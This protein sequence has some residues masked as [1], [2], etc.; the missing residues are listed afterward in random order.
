MSPKSVLRRLG[1]AAALAFAVGGAAS[2]AD[3]PDGLI[4]DPH[5]GDTLFHFYQDHYFTS[6]TGLMVSQHFNRVS[7]HADEAEVLRGGLLLSYGMHKEAGDIFALL[8]EKGAAPPVRD[9]AWFFLAKIRYQRGFFAEA[10]DALGRIE[11]NLPP[12]LEEERVLLKANVAMAR[13]DYATT[14]TVLNSMADPAKEISKGTTSASLYARYN[15]GVA[16]VRSGNP[17]GGSALLDQLGKAPTPPDATE[18]FRSLRDKA[19]VA[20]GFTALQDNKPEAAGPYLERVRLNGSQSNKALLGFG[21]SY[22][23]LKDHKKAL[24]PWT[25]LS[26]RDTSDSAVL[27]ASIALPYAFGQLGAYGQALERYTAAITVYERENT[28]L[29]ESI[30]AIRA[31]KLI[32][33]LLERNPGEE[34]GW[35]WSIRELPQMPHGGH[36]TQVL[37]QHEFQ[38]AFKNY[39]DLQFLTGNLQQWKDSLVVFGDVLDTRRKAYTER[40]PL[41]L[42]KARDI[43][44]SDMSV[45]GAALATALTEAETQADG[46]AFADPKER[47]LLDRLDGVQANLKA[48]GDTP[49]VNAA[50]ERQRLVAGALTWQLAQSY[51]ARLYEAKRALQTLEA[52]INEAKQREAA[53]VQAQRDEPARF[54]QFALRIAELDKRIQALI[55][56]VATLSKEQQGALQELAVA[57]LTRQKDRLV[58][59]STQARFAVAQLYD[60]ADKA[61]EPQPKPAAP[62]DADNAP[63]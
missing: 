36:L 50:R 48:L 25:E 40:L 43:G 30:A 37:S 29:D 47:E 41:V 55:P 42:A 54:D 8:I 53:L 58:A 2:A 31:G 16:L 3:K 9:R 34:M 10:D 1:A 57:E 18:E 49:D 28:G 6:V 45:R 12:D 14:V 22:A 27:E 56:L 15:L 19:N 52:G 51:T 35:F 46:T 63:K 20:L 13:G 4:K 60:R 39:R 11:K 33:G 44:L 59:Y 7:K 21:W 24:V 32:E 26:Q 17:A 62:K 5:Y 61:K 38:E 23:S